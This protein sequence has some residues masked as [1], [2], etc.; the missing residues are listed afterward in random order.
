M[1][2]SPNAIFEK[3]STWLSHENALKTLK[4]LFGDS[5]LMYTGISMTVAVEVE[6]LV[7]RYKKTKETN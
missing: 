4:T 3:F 6:N 2:L 7:K 1:G 5:P